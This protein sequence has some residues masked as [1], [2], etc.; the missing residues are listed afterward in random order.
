MGFKLKIKEAARISTG[1]SSQNMKQMCG[2]AFTEFAKSIGKGR[3]DRKKMRTQTIFTLIFLM[4]TAQ[5]M[6]LKDKFCSN[7]IRQ[8]LSQNNK[9]NCN[10]VR[11]KINSTGRFKTTPKEVSRLFRVLKVAQMNLISKKTMQLMVGKKILTREL[12]LVLQ[13]IKNKAYRAY[14]V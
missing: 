10:Q 9:L 8:N 12:G 13:I 11:Q 3:N 7:W 1:K 14:S 6:I 4:D 2:Q 5:L